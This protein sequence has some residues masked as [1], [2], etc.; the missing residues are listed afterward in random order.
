MKNDD[1][2]EIHIKKNLQHEKKY[3]QTP[4]TSED[5]KHSAT[6]VKSIISTTSAVSK[7]RQRRC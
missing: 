5:A 6:P 2:Y 1:I 7:H 3:F 4:Y